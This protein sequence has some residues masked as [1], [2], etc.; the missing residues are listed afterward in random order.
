VKDN[1]RMRPL[2]WLF[3]LTTLPG[4]LFPYLPLAWQQRRLLGLAVLFSL[5]VGALHLGIEGWRLPMLPLYSLAVL[6][7]LVHIPRRKRTHRPGVLVSALTALLL[8]G[9]SLLPGWV[10]PIM[11]LPN[12]TGPYHVGLL[13]RELVDTARGRRLMVSVWYPAA[14]G[15]DPAPWTRHPREVAFGLMTAFGFPAAAPLLY[16]LGYSTI[17]ASDGVPVLSAHAPFPVLV[18]SHGTVGLRSQSSS[19]FQDLASWGYVVVSIDHTDAAAVT[20]FPNG[21]IRLFDL[22]RFGLGPADPAAIDRSNEVMLPVWVADQRFVYDTLEQ[23]ADDDPLLADALDLN[24]IGSFGHSFGG[25]V[26]VEVCR[27]DERCRAAVNMDG[28]DVDPTKPTARPLLIMSSS[29]T[30][31]IPTA[32]QLWA[33][34]LRSATG[35]A[36]WLEVPKSD[37]FSFTVAPLISPLLAPPD[38]DA[39]AGL[40]V[41]SKYLRVFFDRYLRGE[42]NQLLGPES[43]ATDVRWRTE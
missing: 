26:A 43:G 16:H 27:V 1:D 22:R 20:V 11:T 10:L 25:V 2:E 36:Y 30:N 19:T 29:D 9:A 32:L 33:R 12:P 23:W 42:E 34:Q 41:I 15:G 14:R 40:G 18:F 8:L 38:F 5:L 21:E 17:A 28:G 6:T 31:R 7:P 4:L 35:P 37:H 13:D 24:R 3:L 39:R